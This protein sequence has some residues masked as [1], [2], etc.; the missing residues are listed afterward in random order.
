MPQERTLLSLVAVVFVLFMNEAGFAN[1]GHENQDM[2]IPNLGNL[3]TVNFPVSCSE[4]S[5][6][7]I[8]TGV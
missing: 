6:K 1:D 5:Q 3:G 2:I 7:A 8:N 4:D